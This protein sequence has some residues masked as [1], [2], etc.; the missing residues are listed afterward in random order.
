MFDFLMR[1]SPQRLESLQKRGLTPND[2]RA[3]FTLNRDA[4]TPTGTLARQWDCDPSTATWLVDR[5]ERAGLAKR[6]PSAEDRRVKLVKL[7]PKGAA[8]T[9]E[10]MEEYHHPP[11]EIVALPSG[12][13]DELIRLLE[14]LH[15]SALGPNYGSGVIATK[16]VTT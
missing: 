10:L 11:P 6:F 5:L 8:I 9:K 14:K 2:S 1:S 13:V 12:D 7:T 15:S 3:L 16:A 4:G